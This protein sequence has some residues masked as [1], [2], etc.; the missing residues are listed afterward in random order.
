M[1]DFSNA[2]LNLG[3][4]VKQPKKR[5]NCNFQSLQSLHFTSLHSISIYFTAPSPSHLDFLINL[6]KKKGFFPILVETLQLILI[7]KKRKAVI[8]CGYN[9]FIGLLGFFWRV[10]GEFERCVSE[11]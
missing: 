1:A 9:L 4:R 2:I 7:E 5:N 11:A 3:K 8:I 6:N 10:Y